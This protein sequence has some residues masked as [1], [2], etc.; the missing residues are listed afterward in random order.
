MKI[1][2]YLLHKYL[3]WRTRPALLERHWRNNK[4]RWR[5][6]REK[7]D[8]A[9]ITVGAVQL[10]LTLMDDAR[11]YLD[12]MCRITNQ[13]ARQG[14]QLLAFPEY[15]TF[16]LLGHIPGIEK[17]AANA[18]Q[19]NAGSGDVNV[20]DLF[21]FAG[22]F[23]NRVSHFTFSTLAATFGLYIMAGSMPFP[24]EGQVVNRALLYGPDGKLR[25]TQDKVHLMPLEHQWGFSTGSAFNVF[26]TSVG[27]LAMPVCMDA[28]YFETFRTVAEMGTDIVMVPIANPEPYNQ[29]LALR[30]IWPRVQE[31]L[32]Y[33]IKSAM[34]GQAFGHTLTGKAGVFAPLELTPKLD[35]ILAEAKSFDREEL[36]T[37]TLDLHAL[38]ALQQ[39]HP[40]LGDK[41][42]A[43]SAK[44][45]RNDLPKKE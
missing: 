23:F 44:H 31:S 6:L 17:L 39:N 15:S 29:W 1:K 26:T 9:Q 35:G 10:E 21:R 4:V 24:V 28:T 5:R 37:A 25:G 20:A 16:P 40:Y 30:G 11:E 36:V 8:P 7:P 19:E 2:E 34:V 42:P 3:T 13:A 27:K 12:E 18:D 33:G 32:V 38:W 43:L 45:C 22:P 14:V 41:N